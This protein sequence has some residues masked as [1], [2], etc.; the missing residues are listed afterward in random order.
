MNPSK[1]W[2]RDEINEAALFPLED[3]SFKLIKGP[4]GF[5]HSS[6]K[7]PLP[8]SHN[9]RVKHLQDSVFCFS[10]FSLGDWPSQDANICSEGGQSSHDSTGKEQTR[11]PCHELKLQL[12]VVNT[13]CIYEPCYQPCWLSLEVFKRN[14]LSVRT[15]LRNCMS[16]KNVFAVY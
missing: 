2:L 1:I 12:E 6:S 10:H 14:V 9:G 11:V 5:H 3:G 8:I 15:M 13:E 16:A 4:T 7:P